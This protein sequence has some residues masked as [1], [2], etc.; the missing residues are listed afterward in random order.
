MAKASKA[1]LREFVEN[2]IVEYCSE[3]SRR[4]SIAEEILKAVVKNVL[5]HLLWNYQN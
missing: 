3:I 4:E 1:W 5:F 2:M